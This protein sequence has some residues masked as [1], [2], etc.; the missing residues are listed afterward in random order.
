VSRGSNRARR[1]DGEYEDFAK[2][3][4]FCASI[5]DLGAPPVASELMLEQAGVALPV[6]AFVLLRLADSAGPISVSELARLV[7]LHPTTVSSQ[8]RPLDERGFIERQGD[9]QDRRVSRIS[10]TSAGRAA[11]EQVRD[12]V[13]GQWRIILA[14][15]TP[16]DRHLLAEL[17]DR[18][19]GD[20]QQALRVALDADAAA[21]TGSE[22]A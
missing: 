15:W 22:L 14:G 1:P 9:D 18:A 13:A 17:L 5:F 6:S 19:R 4:D 10:V 21:A 20:M 16:T 12:I 3:V 2:I 7:G 8:L 11:H